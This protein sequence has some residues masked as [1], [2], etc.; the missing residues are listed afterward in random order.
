MSPIMKF[1]HSKQMLV[2]HRWN[3]VVVPDSPFN[4]KFAIRFYYD[5]LRETLL[6]SV[7]APGS[8]ELYP[9]AKYIH[10]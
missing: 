3:N 8:P 9:I 7:V 2:K 4:L 5:I 6:L 1:L 10:K